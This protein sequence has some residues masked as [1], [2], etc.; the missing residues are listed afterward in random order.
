M[1]GI[2]NGWEFVPK[3]TEEFLNGSGN[4]EQVR[5]PHSVKEVPLHYVD[6]GTYQMV[7]GYRRKL[8]VDE[9]L[10]G[11]RLF[12]QFDGAAHIATVYVNA[13]E[14]GHHR[15][16]YTAFRVEI[17]DLVQYGEENLICVKLDTTENGEVPPFG[18]VIDYLTY[19][20]LYREVWL[21][22]RET[23]LISDVFVTTPDLHTANVAITAEN[24]DGCTAQ[25]EIIDGN[26]MVAGRRECAP[27]GTVKLNVPSAKVWDTECPNLYTCRVSLCKDGKTVDVQEVKFGFRTAQFKSDGF[28]LNGKKTFMRGLNRHQCWPYIGYAAP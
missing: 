7:C 22:I 11:K 21:D 12:L 24:A 15:T 5:L 14:A 26:G 3:F 8:E 19:G 18:F 2:C 4:A 17:T 27:V 25:V 16:G 9:A 6:H 23:S 28:Y 1:R 13:Q 10:R 20:G